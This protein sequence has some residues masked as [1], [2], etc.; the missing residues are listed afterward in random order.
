[1]SL[2]TKQNYATYCYI[3]LYAGCVLLSTF[4]GRGTAMRWDDLLIWGVPALVGILG[5]AYL[6][7][8]QGFHTKNFYGIGVSIVMFCGAACLPPLWF[9]LVAVIL[10]LAVIY[11]VRHHPRAAE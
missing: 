3:L 10:F 2:Q 11:V 6:F 9:R 7:F 5:L 8:R 1:M 4:A